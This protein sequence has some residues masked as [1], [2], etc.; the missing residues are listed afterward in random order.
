MDEQK[1]VSMKRSSED[2]RKDQGENSP[3]EAIAPDY[4]YGLCI[5][6]DTDEL[7]KLGIKEFPPIGE[8]LMF[9]VQVKVTRQGEDAN[10]R[11]T[12]RFMDMQITDMALCPK[13][14]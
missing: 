7:D 8:S 3:I 12:E 6:L 11:E 5:H 10:G 2:K 13:G 1:M 9:H 4:P 14:E